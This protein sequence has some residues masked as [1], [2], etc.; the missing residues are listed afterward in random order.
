M[1]DEIR[2]NVA[3]PERKEILVNLTTDLAQ[4]S[5]RALAGEDVSA[6]IQQDKSQGLSLS[7]S[8]VALVQRTILN[9]LSL[10]VGAV[11]RGA[12]AGL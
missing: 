2:S 5:A 1:L 11:V 8:E 7:A 4:L 6:E 3:S 12:L 10:I 9:W